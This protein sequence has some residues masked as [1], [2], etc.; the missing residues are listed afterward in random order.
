MKIRGR[1]LHAAALAAG[2]GLVLLGVA[3]AQGLEFDEDFRNFLIFKMN[4]ELSAS[5]PEGF[6][7]SQ[8]PNI[9]TRWHTSPA[10]LRSITP[11]PAP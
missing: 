9:V 10:K 6:Y 11:L 5:E 3:R 7:K 4:Q 8:S 1:T 2:V